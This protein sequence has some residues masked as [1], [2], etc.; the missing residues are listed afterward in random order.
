M[1]TTSQSVNV[2]DDFPH[3]TTLAVISGAQRKERWSIYEDLAHQLAPKALTHS[4]TRP[5]PTGDGTLRR[6]CA[7]V[8]RKGWV[9]YGELAW[10]VSRLG[11]LLD[12]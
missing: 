1:Q 10:L 11:P 4:A 9:S 3:D 12:W 8:A 7:A 6:V 2:P 5:V